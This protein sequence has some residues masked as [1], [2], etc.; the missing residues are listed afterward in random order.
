MSTDQTEKALRDI[1]DQLR[2]AWQNNQCL[3]C[4]LGELSALAAA[5]LTFYLEQRKH[6]AYSIDHWTNYRTK[7]SK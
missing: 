5:T 2:A 7:E 1:A 3:T 6:G 4:P